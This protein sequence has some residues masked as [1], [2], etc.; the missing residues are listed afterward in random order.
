[1]PRT[2][3]VIRTRDLLDTQQRLTAFLGCNHVV[4]MTHK[5]II[6]GDRIAPI[7]FLNA[8]E[9]TCPYCPDPD[10]VATPRDQKSPRQLWKEAGEP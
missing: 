8:T 1:M 3:A 2:Q 5:D 4:S 6:I 7:L 10:P 9:M